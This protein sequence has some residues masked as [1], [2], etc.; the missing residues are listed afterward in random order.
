MISYVYNPAGTVAESKVMD[1][2]GVIKMRNVF[3]W[4][5]NGTLSEIQSYKADGTAIGYR[6]YK[7]DNV[8][9]RIDS[10]EYDANRRLV[11]RQVHTYSANKPYADETKTFG[12]DG[13]VASRITY[14]RNNLDALVQEKEYTGADKLS[15]RHVYKVDSRGLAINDSEFDG[16]GK[17]ISSTAITYEFFP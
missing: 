4:N 6:T 13:R 8:G 9:N 3:S 14:E 7:Y 17:L 15:L 10:A 5:P 2:K 16:E 12:T 11:S 1:G